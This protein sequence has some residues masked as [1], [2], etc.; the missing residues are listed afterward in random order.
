MLTELEKDNY[1]IIVKT[2]HGFGVKRNLIIAFSVAL[3]QTMFPGINIDDHNELRNGVQDR[4]EA[5]S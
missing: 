3:E 4:F 1:Y 5:V 2:A